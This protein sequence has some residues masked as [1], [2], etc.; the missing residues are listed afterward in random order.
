MVYNQWVRKMLDTAEPS[1]K[2]IL[3]EQLV[4]L[5]NVDAPAKSICRGCT[6]NPPLSWQA[7]QSDP[8]FCSGWVDDLFRDKPDLG[9]KE[10]VWLMYKEVVKRGAEMYMP[11]FEASKGRFGWISGQLDPRLFTESGQMIHDA[12]E[13]STLSPNVMIKVPASMQGTRSSKS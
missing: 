2:P 4:R 9:L 7:V 5:Y 10:L 12:G 6:T 8:N 1:R 3:E 13:L 11:I